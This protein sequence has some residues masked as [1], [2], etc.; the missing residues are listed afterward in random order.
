MA[1]AELKKPSGSNVETLQ[2]L[3]KGGIKRATNN[4]VNFTLFDTRE[5]VQER[6]QR[7]FDRP[8]K[9]TLKGVLVDKSKQSTLQGRLFL[10]DEASQGNAPA[11][12][13]R[14]QIRGGQREHTRVEG[15]LRRQNVIGAGQYIVPGPDV[16]RDKHGN[17]RR[18][19]YQQML[20]GLQA[21]TDPAQNPAAK[22]TKK[23]NVKRSTQG[24][25]VLKESNKKPMAIAK[26]SGAGINLMFIVID[27]A[28]V[29]APIFNFKGF[30][31][32]TARGLFP[33]RWRRAVTRELR[34]QAQ[35]SAG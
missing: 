33:S 3:S 18:G 4:A 14:W 23:G 9:F 21:F 29:Y 16:P 6:M 22:R 35:R 25:F 17:V 13:L 20:A 28:P 26:R 19:T 32:R 15:T 24:W 1:G 27:E 12:Y 10:R 7:V 30:A 8:T 34:K 31:N 11:E 2:R 5:R